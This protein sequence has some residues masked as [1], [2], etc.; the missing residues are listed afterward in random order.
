MDS[1]YLPKVTFEAIPIKDLVSNQ[2]YQRHKSERHIKRATENFDMY[3]LNPVKVSRRDGV[4]Y[5]VNGQHTM[6]IVANVSGS[7]DTPVWCMVYDDLVYKKEADIFAN[8]QKYVKALTPY[9][10]FCANIEAANDKQLLIK[11]MVESYGL[12]ITPVS[13]PCGI[14]AVGALEYLY[15]RYGYELM[16]RTLRVI[17]AAWEGNQ[18]SLGASILK[19]TARVLATYETEIKDEV[20]KEK[21]SMVSVKEVIRCARERSGG[22]LGCAEA[23]LMIYNKKMHNPLSME[24]LHERIPVKAPSQKA[25]DPQEKLAP[26]PSSP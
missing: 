2:E 21:L 5:V 6:E 8:Q 4:N 23:I 9:E 11:D 20:L 13:K 3:Q 18:Q 12:A 7:K 1:I 26:E 24:K 19:G 16:C 14:C 17:I 10:I 15:D 22:T 25:A